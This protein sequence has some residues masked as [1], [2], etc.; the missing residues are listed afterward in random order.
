[1]NCCDTREREQMI[2]SISIMDFV[3]V[4][5]TEYL[6]THPLDKNAIEYFKHY[7]CMKNQAMKD[8]AAKFGPL[9]ISTADL[10]SGSEWEW[11]LQPMPWEGGC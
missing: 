4:E 3:L 1:M 7:N 11:A 9:S 6:D 2:Q 10:A 5:M 8:F